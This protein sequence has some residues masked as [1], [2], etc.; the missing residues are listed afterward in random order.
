M[1]KKRNIWLCIACFPLVTIAQPTDKILQK[2]LQALVQG[3]KGDCGYYVKNLQSGKVAQYN[4][5]SIYPT[6]SIVKVPILIGIMDKLD[7]QQLS[8]HQ[9]LTYTDSLFYSGEDILGSFKNNE[10]ISLAKVI[11]LMLT[12]SDN[13][14]SLWLQQLAGTGTR[15]NEI[16]Q[17]YGFVH[18]RVNSRTMGREVY[19]NEYGWGQTTPK[20]M[21]TFFEYMYSGKI[22]NDSAS[23]KMI[24]LLGRNYWDEE[25]ISQIPATVFVASKN[26]AVS[27][28]RSEV[29]LVMA[30]Q[31]YIVSIFTN[32][33]A[34]K[35]WEPNN[36][37]W[38]LTRSISNCIFAYYN[39]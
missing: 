25:A 37:A 36:E 11:M 17:Q 38:A 8:Y 10:K 16:L 20:E 6:A 27:A 35:S 2:K 29:L 19:K 13:I 28:S 15:I 4:A 14:A 32:N 24:R 39:K 12:T 26:G 3:F 21:A 31:P 34:D 22:I 33:I 30:K 7:K 1:P 18:S 9:S 5:D 23:K